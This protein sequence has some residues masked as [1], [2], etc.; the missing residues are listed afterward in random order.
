MSTHEDAPSFLTPFFQNTQETTPTTFPANTDVDQKVSRLQRMIPLMS[1][2]LQDFNQSKIKFMKF[3]HLFN[4]ELRLTKSSRNL[5]QDLTFFLLNY[6]M[7]LKE[8]N[9]ELYTEHYL[10][11]YPGAMSRL[12]RSPILKHVI[13]MH[14]VCS[15]QITESTNA[16]F[17]SESLFFNETLQSSVFDAVEMIKSTLDRTGP[18]ASHVPLLFDQTTKIARILGFLFQKSDA[19]LRESPAC[20]IQTEKDQEHFSLLHPE[21]AVMSGWVFLLLQRTGDLK[22]FHED[23]YLDSLKGTSTFTRIFKFMCENRV[24][25]REIGNLVDGVGFIY[26][27][28]L[29]IIKKECHW[30][31][32]ELGDF[33]WE[34]LEREDMSLNG[35]KVVADSLKKS[36][37]GLDKDLLFS[38]EGTMLEMNRKTSLQPSGNKGFKSSIGGANSRQSLGKGK[39]EGLRQT[40]KLQ[41]DLSKNLNYLKKDVLFKEIYRIFEVED[42]F[43]IKSKELDA[44]IRDEPL[45]EEKLQNEVQDIVKWDIFCR[46]STFVGRGALDFNTEEMSLTEVV[47]IPKINVTGQIPQNNVKVAYIFDRENPA[48]YEQM[49]WAEFHNGVAVGLQI[50][51]RALESLD[52]QGIRTWIDYQK[53]EYKRYDHAGLMFGLGLQGLFNCFTIAD[54][55]FNLRTCN[56]SRIIST[57]LGL[58]TSKLPSNRIN[59]SEIILKA[60]NLHLEFNYSSASEVKISRIVQSA[61]MISIGLYHKG[62]SK[63]SLSETMLFQIEARPFNEN[64]RDRECHSLCAGFALGIINLSRGSNIPS[65]KEMKLDERLLQYIQGGPVS[66]AVPGEGPNRGDYQSSNLL[67]CGSINTQMTAPSALM[68]LALIHLKSGNKSIANRIKVPD[69]MFDIIQCNPCLSLLKV[70][71]RN[72]ILWGD[73][74]PTRTFVYSQIPEIV[75]FLL[76][77]N[78]KGISDKFYLNSNFANLDYHNLTLVYYNILA[79][80]C[81][82]LAL[83]FAG[84]G[85]AQTRDLII[86]IIET[87]L[88]VEPLTNEFAT[89]RSSKNKLDH[90]SQLNILSV[91]AL[92]LTIV[93]A[94][95]CDLKAFKTLKIL[96]K[97]VK[98]SKDFDA[99]YGFNM[100]I[101]MSI[102]FLFLGNG[103]STFG[104]SDFQ[105]LCLLLSTFPVFPSSINDNR[106]H[107]QALRHFY[108]LAIQDNLFHLIDIDTKK[109]LKLPLELQTLDK[110]SKMTKQKLISP[111][112]LNSFEDWKSLRLLD[113]DY[114]R[115]VYA[116]GSDER[117][118]ANRPRFLFV[119][120]KYPYSVELKNFKDFVLSKL[121]FKEFNHSALFCAN[122]NFVFSIIRKHQFRIFLSSHLSEYLFKTL[123]KPLMPGAAQLLSPSASRYVH[124]LL[125]NDRRSG[126][127]LIKKQNNF[128]YLL[129]MIYSILKKDKSSQLGLC[130]SYLFN[131]KFGES[132]NPTHY[133]SLPRIFDTQMICAFN[134]YLSLINNKKPSKMSC[135]F[136]EWDEQLETTLLRQKLQLFERRTTSRVLDIF[137]KYLQNSC[138]SLINYLLHLPDSTRF[139]GQMRDLLISLQLNKFRGKRQLLELLKQIRN[140]RL[141]N[142][143]DVIFVLAQQRGVQIG[144]SLL[145][146]VLEVYA[147]IP[148]E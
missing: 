51:R 127:S 25:R 144:Q 49:S 114:H 61:A 88:K 20:P 6:S 87:V 106:F 136:S 53:T 66:S 58:A 101:H 91:L 24:T 109:P 8:T 120:K 37:L 74:Q 72:L 115:L 43:K 73:M 76:E 111:L 121:P 63:K 126:D 64:N 44:M 19:N 7:L 110:T 67:D 95:Y 40:V 81:M 2:S 80:S 122:S 65:I 1:V 16:E 17:P 125:S 14:S 108:V 46:L 148:E 113:D 97:K 27:G 135:L 42:E 38:G 26:K 34:L 21:M 128:R 62:M 77:S 117:A 31:T 98:S 137:K 55:Y 105:I 130:D 68:A 102:G 123:L 30:I 90:Y 85:H 131:R 134:G 28:L 59:M 132:T 89:G 15:E 118:R 139:E 52:K 83:K 79:G 13:E 147:T 32:D 22:Q 11:L 3:L 48:N 145:S 82:A 23:F 99:V 9:Q 84:S 50:S 47:E 56:D 100:A 116:F 119:K 4:E 124:R 54:I 35:R 36:F 78:Q 103:S 104:N 140:H 12:R 5:H 18:S 60:F 57:I 10:K 142:P 112:F 141:R 69:T 29:R 33:A 93:C 96:R 39:S 146:V 133:P 143:R 45:T 75:R 71:T 86:E 41:G 129:S 92:S 70:L 138:Q 107:L 94:G